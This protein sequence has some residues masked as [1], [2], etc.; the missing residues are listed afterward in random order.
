M[1][2]ALKLKTLT[3]LIDVRQEVS[4]VQ[5][6]HAVDAD[7]H[8]ACFAEVGD[9]LLWVLGATHR[10]H[11]LV[12]HVRG[13]EAHLTLVEVPADYLEQLV[14]CFEVV[15][16]VIAVYRHRAD[17]ALSVF[18]FFC[19]EELLDALGAER[20]ATVRQ[21]GGRSVLLVEVLGASVALDLNSGGP[22]GFVVERGLI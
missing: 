6:E 17:A 8:V 4:I 13:V 16:H 15:S 20:V 21:D 10:T 14:V 12:G 9:D 11:H 1:V 19:R 2:F 18:S 22:L 5:V 7:S 3:H